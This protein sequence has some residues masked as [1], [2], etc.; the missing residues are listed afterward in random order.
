MDYPGPH[1]ALK[2]EDYQS[3]IAAYPQ[4]GLLKYTN[5]KFT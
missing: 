1:P 4:E 3:I 5:E 2:E